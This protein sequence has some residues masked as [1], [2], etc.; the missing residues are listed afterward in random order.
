[1]QP[2][3]LLSLLLYRS[4]EAVL[5]ASVYIVFMLLANLSTIMKESNKILD[6]ILVILSRILYYCK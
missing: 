5:G 4:S 3:T 6:N 2:F 1:M